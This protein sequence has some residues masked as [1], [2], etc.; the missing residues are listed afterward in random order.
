MRFRLRDA[1]A[2]PGGGPG[3][4]RGLLITVSHAV[5][6]DANEPISPSGQCEV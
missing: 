6:T 1:L 5:K 2:L 4:G 3:P